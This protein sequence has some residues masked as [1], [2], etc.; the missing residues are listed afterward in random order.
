[1]SNSFSS[2]E[3]VGDERK[4]PKPHHFEVFIVSKR[5]TG[6]D[7]RDALLD[8]LACDWDQIEVAVLAPEDAHLA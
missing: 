4:D 6:A 1:M 5:V 8:C 7:V 2:Y 3:T